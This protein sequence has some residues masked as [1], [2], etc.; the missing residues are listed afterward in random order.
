MAKSKMTPKDAKMRD[1]VRDKDA[2]TKDAVKDYDAKT[3]EDHHAKVMD[4]SKR[5]WSAISNEGTYREGHEKFFKEFNELRDEAQAMD[6][7]TV[8]MANHVAPIYD[9]IASQTYTTHIHY[10]PLITAVANYCNGKPVADW[11]GPPDQ[12]SR[13]PSPHVP[14]SRPQSAGPSKK[15]AQ[16]RISDEFVRSDQDDSEGESV[17]PLEGDSVKPRKAASD[18]LPSTEG[19]ELHATKCSKCALRKHGG[20]HVNPKASKKAAT[21][22]FECN[23]WKQKCSHAPTRTK[24]G[25]D[26][27]E[28][29][30]KESKR[31]RKPTQVPPGQPGQFIGE[32]RSTCSDIVYIFSLAESFAPEIMKKLEN[33]ESGRSL[34]LEKMEGLSQDIARLTTENRSTREWLMNRLQLVWESAEQRDE[35]TSEALKNIWEFAGE[36]TRHIGLREFGEKL[37]A[38]HKLPPMVDSRQTTL[39]FALSS[40][41][42]S[43]ALSSKK[44][45]TAQVDDGT[46]AKRRKLGE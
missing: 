28:A 33:Y 14:A 30:P 26:E 20:C 4:W 16:P 24:K 19:M 18:T 45:T 17:K 35:T 15:K 13:S 43:Q 23:H 1:V 29:P 3:K 5:L 41:H 2:K 27:E 44:R 39:P 32:C 22:C 36:I 10:K 8:T 42:P 46:V 37:E 21:A 6:I 7:T 40:T 38:L 25:E 12:Y 34:L 11:K 31:R 9:H